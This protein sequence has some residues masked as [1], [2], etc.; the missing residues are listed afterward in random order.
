MAIP[1]A[2]HAYSIECF[3]RSLFTFSYRSRQLPTRALGFFFNFMEAEVSMAIAIR[4]LKLSESEGRMIRCEIDRT[5]SLSYAARFE[6]EC[7][8]DVKR[9]WVDKT[10]SRISSHD[11]KRVGAI[12]EKAIGERMNLRVLGPGSWGKGDLLGGIEVRGT[13]NR[14]GP[15]RSYIRDHAERPLHLGVVIN[16]ETVYWMGWLFIWEAR[17]LGRFV[18]GPGHRPHWAVPQR[19]L[20][21]PLTFL[22]WLQI[23]EP[24]PRYPR[25]NRPPE[26]P[27]WSPPAWVPPD[28]RTPGRGPGFR[29]S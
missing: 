26:L 17:L 27:E 2:T 1:T 20:R 4:N 15:L 22:R 19:L 14:N 9:G 7:A 11:A 29:A 18:H 16:E 6:S 25:L 8:K 23:L 21:D 10:V 3:S 13:A 24:P 5:E 12:A 28:L